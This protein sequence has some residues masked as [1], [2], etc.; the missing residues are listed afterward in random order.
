MKRLL[1]LLPLALALLVRLWARHTPETVERLFSQ[2][3]YPALAAPV[4]RAAALCP[5]P[6]FGLGVLALLGYILWSLRQ[7]RWFRVLAVLGLAA[8]VFAGGWSLNYLRLPLEETLGLDVRAST[9][10][11]LV[12]LCHRLAEDADERWQEAPET[13]LLAAAPDAL[14]AAAR[15]WPIPAGRWGAPRAALSSGLLSRWL[16]EGFIS[17]WTCEAL[18]NANIPAAT[19]PFVACHEAAHVRGF[20]REEDANLVAYLACEASGDA[21]YR[22]SGALKALLYAL[23]A[24]QQEDAGAYARLYAS[25]SSGVRADI[26]AHETFWNAYR[27]TPAAE[28][29]ARVNDTYLQ[30]VAQDQNARSYGRLVDL[31]LALSR[32]E[33]QVNTKEGETM[34]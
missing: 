31:L 27:G 16:I 11:E 15:A 33:A 9:Q 26:D 7:G 32:A 28:V 10:E 30:S 12:S 14:N 3:V 18:V 29:S 13:D 6:V 24:L 25:L 4:S 20:A 17:P 19:L 23:R 1:A 2:G 34:T 21:Y 22:Y 5:V 8:A